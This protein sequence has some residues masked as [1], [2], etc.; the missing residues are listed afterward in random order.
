MNNLYDYV[1]ENRDITKIEKLNKLTNIDTFWDDV[2]K[3]T[4]NIKSDHSI[5]RWE[6]SAEK[7]YEILTAGVEA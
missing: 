1:W 7:R 2:R 4:R 6:F 5:N 3:L